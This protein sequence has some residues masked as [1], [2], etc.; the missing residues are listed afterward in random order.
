MNDFALDD[1]ELNGQSEVWLD[2]ESTAQAVL[3][4][5]GGVSKAR[6]VES[7]T[8][9]QFSSNLKA[10]IIVCL[11]SAADYGLTVSAWLPPSVRKGLSGG[12]Q[13]QIDG[14]AELLRQAKL[15]WLA[16]I[17]LILNGGIRSLGLERTIFELTIDASAEAIVSKSVQGFPSP[18]CLFINAESHEDVRLATM[19]ESKVQH[20]L[21]SI[22]VLRRDSYSST[23][24][25]TVELKGSGSIR[26]GAKVK[27]DG[28]ASVF[29]ELYSRGTLGGIRYRYLTG[30]AAINMLSSWSP[31]GHPE[32]PDFY[33]PAQDELVLFATR[34]DRML[35]VS[36]EVA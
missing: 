15:N 6:F 8:Q 30:D 14:S 7:T 20:W 21:H 19:L 33:I 36:R 27:L 23:G 16:E 9:I 22:G 13:E 24:V 29:I 1:G 3:S 35:D 18:A 5:S 32:Q 10:A 12:A 34:D 4:L 25:A 17:E 11:K 31:T 28:T 2:T 26:T